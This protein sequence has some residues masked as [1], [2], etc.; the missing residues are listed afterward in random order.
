MKMT[1]NS[2]S[3]I[4]KGFNSI[5]LRDFM[6]YECRQRLRIGG[7]ERFTVNAPDPL[8]RIDGAWFVCMD[9]HIL[10]K[11]NECN[12]LSFGINIDP[13]F[14]MEMNKNFDCHVHSFDPLI[15]ADFFKSIR[16]VNPKLSN[17][18]VLNINKKWKFYSIGIS[19]KSYGS[20]SDIAKG[21]FLSLGD[22]LRLTGL[23]GKI[24]DIFKIDI[25]GDEKKVFHTLDVDYACKY[26][27]QFMFET[28]K[29]FKFKELAKFEKCFRMFH[30]D[31]RLFMK[32]FIDTPT[33]T[34]T[35]FQNPG[36][37]LLEIKDFRNE[38]NLAEY[39]FPSVFKLTHLN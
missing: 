6:R 5:K 28:H 16:N 29:N 30:R 7:E 10:P 34:L 20:M 23:D 19:D 1:K 36:G 12:V 39:L 37:F 38:I 14:D 25:E 32:D 18:Y 8:Y 22:I 33:G 17:G 27:K 4:K 24:I 2:R 9:N 26:F 3:T 35:E 11:K 31:G 21:S 15:E 13:S